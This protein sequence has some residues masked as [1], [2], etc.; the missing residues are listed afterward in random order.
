VALN[1][2]VDK[3]SKAPKHF[4]LS[5][6]GGDL[7]PVPAEICYLLSFRELQLLNYLTKSINTLCEIES[8]KLKEK[9]QASL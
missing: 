9:V 2:A 8:E 3:Q 1:L 4:L 6:M 7:N 5:E